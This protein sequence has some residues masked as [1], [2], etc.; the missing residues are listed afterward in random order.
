[1]DWM[2]GEVLSAGTY[3]YTNTNFGVDLKTGQLICH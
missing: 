2:S 1:M 3:H